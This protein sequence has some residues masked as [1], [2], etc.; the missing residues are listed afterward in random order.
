VTISGNK[1]FH[2]KTPK[3][4]MKMIRDGRRERRCKITHQTIAPELMA[5][6]K[7]VTFC[8]K[9]NFYQVQRCGST[10]RA[11][12]KAGHGRGVCGSSRRAQ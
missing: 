8:S 4:D 11:S 2:N 12:T 1:Y 3:N 9:R 7:P 6:V 10:H 5:I